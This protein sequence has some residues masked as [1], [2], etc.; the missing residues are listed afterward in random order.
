[1]DEAESVS[2][3]EMTAA[4]LVDSIMHKADKALFHAKMSGKNRVVVYEAK[5]KAE[6]D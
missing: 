4:N 5:V 2:R 3:E 1:M 6:G